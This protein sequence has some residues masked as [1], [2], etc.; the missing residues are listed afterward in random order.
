MLVD[1]VELHVE[2]DGAGRDLVLVNGAFC[3]V[4]LWDMVVA[5]LAPRYRVIRF[6]VR[7]TGRSGAGPAD[8]YTFERYADDIATIAAELGAPTLSL[9]GMAWGARVSLITAARHPDLVERLILSD[10]SID[11]ADVDAQ[12]RGVRAARAARVAAG[13]SEVRKPP[14]WNH[15]DDIDEA[16]RALAATFLHPDLYPAAEAVLQPTLI[17]TGEHDPNLASS[18]RALGALTDGR[19]E[20]LAHTGHGSVLQRPDLVT[21][22]ALRFLEP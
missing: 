10:F 3:T 15:H 16:R 12:Q 13:I 22:V 5:A 14:G 2:V 1:G 20:V 19:L 21:E 4:R 18:R 8:G 9:W 17:C 7:G 11:P 6:D